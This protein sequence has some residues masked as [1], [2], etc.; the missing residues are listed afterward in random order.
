M[1]FHKQSLVYFDPLTNIVTL[2]KVFQTAVNEANKNRFL[3]VSINWRGPILSYVDD[4]GKKQFVDNK[5]GQF[6]V[7]N[8]VKI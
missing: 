8:Y 1:K 4:H 7:F 6:F 3:L 2:R 5:R